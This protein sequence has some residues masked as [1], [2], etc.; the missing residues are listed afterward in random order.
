M[1]WRRFPR[2]KDTFVSLLLLTVFK[3]MLALHWPWPQRLLI[4]ARRSSIS[5]TNTEL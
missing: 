3:K 1:Q 4:T 5:F 2:S